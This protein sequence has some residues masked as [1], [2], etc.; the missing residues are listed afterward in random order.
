MAVVLL[1]VPIPYVRSASSRYL[2]PE[3]NFI[4]KRFGGEGSQRLRRDCAATALRAK[5]RKLLLGTCNGRIGE[6]NEA[7]FLSSSIVTVI[8]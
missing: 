3:L 8:I 1:N 5:C 7:V 6:A 2:A 4:R